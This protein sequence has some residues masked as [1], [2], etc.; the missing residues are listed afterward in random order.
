[1]S[2]QIND[3]LNEFRS[4]IT[5]PEKKTAFEKNTGLQSDIMSTGYEIRK[6]YLSYLQREVDLGSWYWWTNEVVTG[7]QTLEQARLGIY[8]SEEAEYLRHP[9][10]VQIPQVEI[11]P[12]RPP[13][14]PLP[15]QKPAITPIKK[16][17]GIFIGIGLGIVAIIWIIARIFKKRG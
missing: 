2:V 17:V 10:Q 7:V 13:E 4:K 16:P 5:D 8:S 14:A 15:A 9:P 3:L 6:Y 11:A 12:H 1:M